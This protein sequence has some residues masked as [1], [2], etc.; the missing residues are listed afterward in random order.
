MCRDVAEVTVTA[1]IL[2]QFPPRTR[3]CTQITLTQQIEGAVSPAHAGMH[4]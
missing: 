4:P 3:G 1:R 2:T